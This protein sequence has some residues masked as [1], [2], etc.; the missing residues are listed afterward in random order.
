MRPP[1]SSVQERLAGIATLFREQPE[2][3]RA[4]NPPAQARLEDGL[5]CHVAGPHGASISTD[6]PAALG[7]GATAPNPGWFLRAAL[8]S[9]NATVIAM[10]AAQRGITLTGLEVTVSSESDTRGMLGLDERISAAMQAL[11]MHVKISAAGVKPEELREIVAWAAA[12]SPVGCTDLSG[13]AVEVE[14]G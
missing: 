6:M 3:A 13:A 10:R 1:A 2:K 7:G 5:R 11:R 9:C 14:L 8:A 4:T 12:H